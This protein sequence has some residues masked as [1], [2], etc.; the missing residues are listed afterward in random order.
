MPGEICFGTALAFP[1]LVQ[2]MDGVLADRNGDS[3]LDLLYLTANAVRSHA[4]LGTT[5]DPNSTQGQNT[6]NARSMRPVQFDAN[7]NVE[8]L[9][10]T[11]VGLESWQFTASSNN[12]VRIGQ[13]PLIIQVATFEVGKM[14]DVGVTDVI[15]LDGSQL[16]VYRIEGPTNATTVS[17]IGVPSTPNSKLVVGQLTN[18]MRSD[19]LL[20]SSNG[21]TAYVGGPAGI[22][23]SSARPTPVTTTVSDAAIGDLDGDGDGDI[24]FVVQTVPGGPPGQLGVMRGNNTGSFANPVLMTVQDLGGSVAMADLDNDGRD[25]VITFRNG[26]APNRTLLVYRGRA[27]G[28]LEMPVTFPLPGS[29][30]KLSVRGS[31]NGDMVPDIVVTDT[32]GSNVY[33]FPSNP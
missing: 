9:I 3:R 30:G 7:P 29:Q 12:Y 23:S 2:P 21:I 4:N 1:S 33:V 22:A 20:L 25:D 28:G 15:S 18:D 5:L 14:T 31:F 13:Y 6:Q 17:S 27:D 16:D 10:A 8:L 11:D 19:V 26:A 32:F 24:V